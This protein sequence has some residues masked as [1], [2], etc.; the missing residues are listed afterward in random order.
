[1]ASGARVRICLAGS[2][3]PLKRGEV[4]ELHEG[5]MT[6]VSQYLGGDNSYFYTDEVGLWHI[7]GDQAIMG[8][9]AR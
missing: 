1:M 6:V 8:K 5:G 7:T 2:R 3:V 4:G 9:L